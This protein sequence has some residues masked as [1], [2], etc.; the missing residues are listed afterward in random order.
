MIDERVLLTGSTS[1]EG[2]AL[3]FSSMIPITAAFTRM[4]ESCRCS[5]LGLFHKL[6]VV[7]VLAITV[8]Q[9]TSSSLARSRVLDSQSELVCQI[10]ATAG[11]RLCITVREA[12]LTR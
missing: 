5:R 9:N 2:N 10:L 4:N 12:R 7:V 6:T 11:L 1:C 3:F 8:I